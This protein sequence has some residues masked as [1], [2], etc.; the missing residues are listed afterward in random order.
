MVD[1]ASHNKAWKK[2]FKSSEFYKKYA[3]HN[4][5]H[6]KFLHTEAEKDKE[7]IQVES[8]YEEMEKKFEDLKKNA[9]KKTLDQF[10]KE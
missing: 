4:E 2:H 8:Q 6:E 7:L 10:E 3:Q 5:Q 9:D 1:S